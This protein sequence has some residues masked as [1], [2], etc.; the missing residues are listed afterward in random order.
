[1]NKKLWMVAGAVLVVIFIALWI[2]ASRALNSDT[3]GDALLAQ[4][5]KATGFQISSD[6]LDLS[7]FNGLEMNGVTA[8]GEDSGASYKLQ[9]S[10]LVFRVRF[11][12]LLSGTVSVN[13][14]LLD[15][16]DVLIVTRK[17]AA[18]K[19]KIK[20]ETVQEE[21]ADPEGGSLRFEVAEFRVNNARIRL[22]SETQQGTNEDSLTIDGL[23]ISLEDIAFDPQRE[24]L[25]QRFSGRG[26]VSAERL[27]LSQLPVRHL[28]G[29]L[30]AS[31][32]LAEL[33]KLSMS[34]D[35]GDF[36]ASFKLDLNPV[37]FQYAFS[38][39][40]DPIDVNQIV[41]LSES[42]SLG[43][44]RLDLSGQGQG[45]ESRNLQAKGNLHLENGNI[46]AHPVLEQVQ[47]VVGMQGLVGGEY[48]ATDA[49]FTVDDNRINLSGFAL[50]TA[51]AGL[52]VGGWADLD[53]PLKIDI[54][55]RTP[56][57]GLSIPKVP[58]VALDTLADERGW[59]TV[60]LEVNGTLENPRVVPD[61]EALTDQGVKGAVR[62]LGDLLGGRRNN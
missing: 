60:P 58:P 57:E 7:I 39:Q 38:G 23:D 31:E 47:K 59:V 42:G 18:T 15:E 52:D 28:Q 20:S 48:R 41:G 30:V 37:P 22:Q 13:Q 35:Q 29:E 51:L 5:S 62:K 6:D 16:P 45:P 44:G 11:L 14:I 24:R 53:G 17:E 61:I 54:G 27:V 34:M 25:V 32:G 10:R 4:V 9:L 43:P 33:S 2:L 12:P 36:E 46:P 40:V 56:R 49:Q 19:G 55:L 21:P 1:M 3:V 26:T 8:E 50:E